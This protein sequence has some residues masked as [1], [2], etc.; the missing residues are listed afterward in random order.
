MLALVIYAVYFTVLDVTRTWVEQGK[1]AHIWW[2][3][4]VMFL[5]VGTLYVPWVKIYYRSRGRR[6]NKA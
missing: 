5:V 1:A 4:A 6:M 3:P 2:V